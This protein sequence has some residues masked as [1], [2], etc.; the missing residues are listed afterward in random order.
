MKGFGL[1]ALNFTK[2]SQKHYKKFPKK[3]EQLFLEIPGMSFYWAN[4]I[5]FKRITL[6]IVDVKLKWSPVTSLFLYSLKT[7]CKRVVFW[8]FQ[9]LYKETSGIK[10]VNCK[11]YFVKPKITSYWESATS[12]NWIFKIFKRY[13]F[14]S[15]TVSPINVNKQISLFETKIWLIEREQV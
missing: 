3:L 14:S 2:P 10:W 1:K 13:V 7:S 6:N 15:D 5:I 8:C 12:L 9:G 11:W 4:G